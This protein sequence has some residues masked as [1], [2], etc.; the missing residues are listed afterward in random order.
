MHDVE[1]TEEMAWRRRAMWWG[2]RRQP[3]CLPVGRKIEEYKAAQI[4][5]MSVYLRPPFSCD[6]MTFFTIFASSTRNARMI[7]LFCDLIR[8]TVDEYALEMLTAT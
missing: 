6:L 1:R 4:H 3:A 2:T 7:L 8:S 5:Q